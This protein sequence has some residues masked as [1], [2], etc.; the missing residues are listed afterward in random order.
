MESK[1]QLPTSPTDS[2]ESRQ[3]NTIVVAIDFTSADSYLALNPAIALAHELDLALSLQPFRVSPSPIPS[4]TRGEND[5]Q[6]HKRIRAQ[7]RQLDTKRY[8]QT[9][10]IELLA[11]P[12]GVDPTL[13]HFGL[14][15][16]SN[17]GV[18]SEYAQIVFQEFWKNELD[19]EREE[20]IVN[21]LRRVGVGRTQFLK[22]MQLRLSEIREDLLSREVFSVPTFLV[23]GERFIGRQHIPMIRTLLEV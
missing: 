11:D 18:G 8:A 5:A 10:G 1:E 14:L 22:E 23:K 3:G 19:L 13:A 2:T 16:A 9:R 6:R 4:E 21:V 20:E 15:L 17:R 12:I 7:Y